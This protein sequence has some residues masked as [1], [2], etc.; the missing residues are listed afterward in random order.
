MPESFLILL[1]AGI[2]LAAAV[3]DPQQVTLHWL[4]LC[5]ILALATAALSMFF[6]FRQTEPVPAAMWVAD[7]CVFAAILAQLAFAQTARRRAQQLFAWLAF[8]F[9][10]K[11]G[12]DQI[13][14]PRLAA[15]ASALGVA[16]MC[17]LAL[18]DM[19]LGHAYLT[20]SKMTIAPFLRL[21]AS[22]AGTLVWR[23]ILSVGL[24][25]LILH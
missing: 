11:I 24:S 17:G 22:L 16:A 6:L 14:A 12:A 2:M 13:P 1:A 23:T 15:Y 5:G 21:N 8:F 25:M 3:S 7:A 9:A 20:A 18:M 4:R 10:V 19:L